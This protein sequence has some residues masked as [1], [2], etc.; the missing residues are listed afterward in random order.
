MEVLAFSPPILGQWRF[1]GCSTRGRI[2]LTQ[3][4]HTL[5]IFLC[6][7]VYRTMTSAYQ[8]TPLFGGYD[9]KLFLKPAIPVNGSSGGYRRVTI[10]RPSICVDWKI[11]SCALSTVLPVYLK[12]Y[13][14]GVFC[15]S[16]ICTLSTCFTNSASASHTS[17]AYSCPGT[18]TII[19][20]QIV[21]LVSRSESL[22]GPHPL[23][24]PVIYPFVIHSLF[25]W[26]MSSL[27]NY[28]CQGTYARLRLAGHLLPSFI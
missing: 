8:G 18:N 23:S 4:I 2:L 15:S 10:P 20:M 3:R 1:H 7:K 27:S 22:P 12:N 19:T 26:P 28:W 21:I 14:C 6:A 5:S 17:P 13:C 16:A 25:V 9:Q 11:P 24:L